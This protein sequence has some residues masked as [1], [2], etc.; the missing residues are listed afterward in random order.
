MDCPLSPLSKTNTLHV[1]E[2]I[3]SPYIFF[4]NMVSKAFPINEDYCFVCPEF[5]GEGCLSA[6]FAWQR[7]SWSENAVS[8][9]F[10]SITL[11]AAYKVFTSLR[12]ACHWIHCWVV[13]YMPCSEPSP[14]RAPTARSTQNFLAGFH[15]SVSLLSRVHFCHPTVCSM[16]FKRRLLIITPLG[17]QKTQTKSTCAFLSTI[18]VA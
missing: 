18:F 13:S 9:R 6:C 15:G 2:P 14:N 3:L 12:D 17:A 7:L 1:S 4:S 11:A 16:T 8:S 5:Y 10:W